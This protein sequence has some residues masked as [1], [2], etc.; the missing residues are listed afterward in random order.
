MIFD[1]SI[2]PNGTFETVADGQ[3]G[4]DNGDG[5]VDGY[6]KNAADLSIDA[7]RLKIQATAGGHAA[8]AIGVVIIPGKTY[9]IKVDIIS[10]TA[11]GDIKLRVG[12]GILSSVFVSDVTLNKDET[13]T[14][15]YTAGA[16]F[17]DKNWFSFFIAVPNTISD[18]VFIDNIKLEPASD[19]DTSF[20]I[21]IDESTTSTVLQ[22]NKGTV[23][24]VEVRTGEVTL[25]DDNSTVTVNSSSSV[26]TVA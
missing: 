21:S 17:A 4:Y 8:A 10:G 14:L 23:A 16:A 22:L 9:R 26:V 18:T 24:T 1:S 25:I 7:N 20:N 12:T 2:F 6:Q 5:T 11:S 13:N 3:I 15:T 19:N